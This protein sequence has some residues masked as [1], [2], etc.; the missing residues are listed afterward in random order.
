MIKVG[1]LV[2]VVKPKSCCGNDKALGKTFVA[3]AIV[4]ET[5]VCDC[6]TYYTGLHVEMGTETFRAAGVRAYRCIKIDP[7]SLQD[8]T[9]TDREL[10]I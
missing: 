4:N 6:G 5:T 3:T 7:P 1:D 9:T 10:A 8:E 2:M